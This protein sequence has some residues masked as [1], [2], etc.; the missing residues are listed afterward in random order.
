MVSPSICSYVFPPLSQLVA[1]RA[2]FTHARSHKK[3]A[4][5]DL[6]LAVAVDIYFAFISSGCRSSVVPTGTYYFVTMAVPRLRYE[7]PFCGNRVRER[8]ICNGLHSVQY[9][10]PALYYTPEAI[11]IDRPSH[12]PQPIIISSR[13]NAGDEPLATSAMHS[14]PR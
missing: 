14:K 8:S 2:S 1:I 12:E 3:H 5:S 10:P 4:H 13:R 9:T 7:Q 11:D 6:F